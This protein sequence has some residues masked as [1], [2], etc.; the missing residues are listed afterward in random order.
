[1]TLNIPPS[2]K[3]SVL[4][5]DDDTVIT[6]MIKT[7]LNQQGYE[8]SI[9]NSVAEAKKWLSQNIAPDIVIL[10]YNMPESLGIELSPLLNQTNI[11]FILLT[12][13]SDDH[14]IHDASQHGAI[15]YLVKPISTQQLIAAIETAIPKAN[16]ITN[17]EESVSNLQNTLDQKRTVSLACGMIAMHLGTDAESAEKAIRKMARDNNRKLIEVAEDV[18][19]AVNLISTFKTF[20]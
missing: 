16:K 6:A 3:M 4:L 9:V 5:V 18:C 2:E 15:G 19:S 14:I 7:N 1:M 10:D 20:I 11:P 17:L 13:Y 8:T 12:A